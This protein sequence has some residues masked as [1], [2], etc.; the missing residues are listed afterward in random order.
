MGDPIEQ[1][2]PEVKPP[3]TPKKPESEAAKSFWIT[4]PGILAQLAVLIGAIAGL[5]VTLNEVGVI[6][7]RP[8]PTFTPTL[9]STPTPTSTRTPTP[10]DSPTPTSTPTSTPAPTVTPTL[11]PTIASS[12][13]PTST[14][15]PPTPVPVPKL[16]LCVRLLGDRVV[17]REGPDTTTSVRGRLPGDVCLTFDQRLPDNSWVRIAQEQG[18]PSNAAFSLGWVKAELLSESDEIVH[19]FPYIG[20]DVYNGFYCINAGSGMNV[21]NCADTACEQIAI[22]SW[23]ECLIFDARLTDSSWLRIGADQEDETY[24]PL[25]GSWVSTDSFSLVVREF[26]TFL[27]QHDMRPYFEL[28]PVVTPP[29][30]P[31]G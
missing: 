15:L 11:T 8:T 31:Q 17:V 14:P 26:Q 16:E 21:R 9:T 10:T 4:L 5:I 25:A 2:P 6:S 19:L 3:A 23:Q 7:L 1:N 30:T 12:P 22:L 13:T 24:S 18:D 29:P 27:S 28:L 20:E